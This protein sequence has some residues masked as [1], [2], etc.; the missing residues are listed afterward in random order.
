M[1]I[2]IPGARADRILSAVTELNNRYIFT[3]IIFHFGTNYIPHKSRHYIVSEMTQFL[4][5]MQ[6][7]MPKSYITLSEILPRTSERYMPG[8]NDLNRRMR[9]FCQDNGYGRIHH[10]YFGKSFLGDRRAIC[11][12]GV[13][14]NYFGINKLQGSLVRY[15]CH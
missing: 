6:K 9:E 15:L 3:R 12:D 7:F 4:T 5:A 2:C 14:L 1:K 8:I 11:R 13:H 10:R